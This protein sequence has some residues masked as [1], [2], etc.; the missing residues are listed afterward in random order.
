M[1]LWNLYDIILAAITDLWR[2]W[3]RSVCRVSSIFHWHYR[4]KFFQQELQ[5]FSNKWLFSSHLILCYKYKVG[6]RHKWGFMIIGGQSFGYFSL[7]SL[8]GFSLD[9]PDWEMRK[10]YLKISSR[11]VLIWCF[12]LFFVFLLFWVR[13]KVSQ[14]ILSHLVGWCHFFLKKSTFC[15]IWLRGSTSLSLYLAPLLKHEKYKF[16]A[17][18]NGKQWLTFRPQGYKTFFMLNSTEHEIFPAQKC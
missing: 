2:L 16:S 15:A 14:Y 4:L 1:S 17:L 11:P 5:I 10:I 13:D 3:C 7:F 12:E 18:V 6:S 8:W 9:Q